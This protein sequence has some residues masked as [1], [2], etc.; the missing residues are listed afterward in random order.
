M[1]ELMRYIAER[2]LGTH[3][4]SAASP[5]LAYFNG[6]V[7]EIG[8]VVRALIPVLI[9]LALLLFIWGLVKFIFASGDEKEVAV[10]KQ[11]MIW[12]I[13]ALFVIVSVWGL[14]ALLIDITQVDPDATVKA[15][16]TGF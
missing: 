11:R 4:A 5:T 6:A 3:I 16:F 9:G 13:I 14:V 2:I 8:K 7:T 15:P 12:G 10:G 1:A